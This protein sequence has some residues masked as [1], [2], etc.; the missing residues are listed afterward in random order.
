[1]EPDP[2]PEGDDTLSQVCA[3]VAHHVLGEHPDGLVAMVTT[4]ASPD[5]GDGCDVGATAYVHPGE[6]S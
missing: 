4:K 3:L 6:P 5:E 1:M 2:L